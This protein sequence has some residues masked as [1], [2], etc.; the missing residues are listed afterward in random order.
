MSNTQIL[1]L[2]FEFVSA[3]FSKEFLLQFIFEGK[4][5]SKLHRQGLKFNFELCNQIL[6]LCLIGFHIFDCLD[7]DDTLEFTD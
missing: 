3:F 6:L 1:K 2:M 7:L 4:W 5:L